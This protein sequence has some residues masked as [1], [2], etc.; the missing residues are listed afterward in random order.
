MK[1]SPTG[2]S[3]CT[4]PAPA[5]MAYRF[6]GRTMLDAPLSFLGPT[7]ILSMS[8]AALIGL[9]LVRRFVLPRLRV[10][11]ADSEFV[12]AVVQSI[13]VFYGLAL[14]LIAVNVWQTY[15]DVART[16]SLEAIT[17]AT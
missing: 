12:G 8:A 9:L 4:W 16:V 6:P 1:R 7:I 11:E 2:A 15:N 10:E 13:M 14:A 3:G 5:D 17:F